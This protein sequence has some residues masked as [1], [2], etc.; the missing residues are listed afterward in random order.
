M[1]LTRNYA[2]KFPRIWT[3]WI[4]IEAKPHGYG[5]FYA[6]V[7]GLKA[8]IVEYAWSKSNHAKLCPILWHIPFGLLNVMPRCTPVDEADLRLLIETNWWNTSIGTMPVEE[9]CS[10]FGRLKGKFVAVDYGD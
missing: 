10:S 4:Q 5:K 8:N 6:F 7:C 2:F 3:R 1:V 9:K